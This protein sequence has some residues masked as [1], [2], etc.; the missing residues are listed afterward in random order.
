VY[1][2]ASITRPV[3]EPDLAQTIEPSNGGLTYTF[4]LRQGVKFHNVAPV[5]GRLFDADDVLASYAR[6]S[7]G[8]IGFFG[9]N[10]SGVGSPSFGTSLEGVV[11]RVSSPDKNTVVFTL[12]KP[13]ATFL[14]ILATFNFF[15][16][17]PREVDDGYDP[18][19]DPKFNS[20]QEASLKELDYNKRRA[21]ILEMLVYLGGE[22]RHIPYGWQSIDTYTLHRPEV[23]NI[24][25][26]RSADSTNGGEPVG[27]NTKHWWL[28]T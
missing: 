15:W 12:T 5:N 19:N 3:V 25:A 21:I 17:Y 14:N 1:P 27:T 28:A 20:L 10:R 9:A 6:F 22:M 13:N 7:G 16:I 18:L 8:Q 26:F 24:S 2:R 23:R 11:D 4:K